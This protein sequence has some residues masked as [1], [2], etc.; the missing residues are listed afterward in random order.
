M[1][2]LS[3]TALALLSLITAYFTTTAHASNFEDM[4]SPRVYAYCQNGKL[5]LSAMSL[6]FVRSNGEAR[7]PDL[8]WY[9]LTLQFSGNEVIVS[10]TNSSKS[11]ALGTVDATDAQC[12]LDAQ[13]HGDLEI[14]L[15]PGVRLRY[16]Q[17]IGSCHFNFWSLI[18]IPMPDMGGQHRRITWQRGQLEQLVVESV[19][20]HDLK[21]KTYKSDLGFESRSEC[22]QA[23]H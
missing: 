18:P 15:N 12:V 2:S 4:P 22:R 5:Q 19:H 23:K 13:Y 11:V 9:G 7:S 21:S 8:T 16:S 1:K 6:H 17:S 20:E 3:T 14:R 10:Q